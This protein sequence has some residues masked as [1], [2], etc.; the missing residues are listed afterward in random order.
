MKKIWIF[1]ALFLTL[2]L[3][4]SI[5]SCND[6]SP[7]GSQGTKFTGGSPGSTPTVVTSIIGNNDSPVSMNSIPLTVT[8]YVGNAYTFSSLGFGSATTLVVNSLVFY[9]GNPV[10]STSSLEISFYN[11]TISGGVTT[12]S[13]IFNNAVTLAASAPATWVTSTTGMP[14]TLVNPS[15][16]F[17]V[18][19]DLMNNINIGD[20]SLGTCNASTGTQTG[21]MPVSFPGTFT[22]GGACYEIYINVN[23]N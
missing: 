20:K 3:T 19:H 17:L 16:L 23:T 2:T 11:Q 15:N 5:L 18:A 9:A 22:S 1:G 4:I 13:Q 21:S 14:I 7:A 8:N 12:C 6:N 10:A